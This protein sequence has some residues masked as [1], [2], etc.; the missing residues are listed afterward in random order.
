MSGVKVS[1]SAEVKA[2]QRAKLDDRVTL[3]GV[4][5]MGA[6]SRGPHERS[7]WGQASLL[8]DGTK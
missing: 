1:V 2:S 5:K 8:T 4:A 3:G 7:E 6:D